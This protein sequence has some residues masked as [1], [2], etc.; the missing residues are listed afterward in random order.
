MDTVP[1]K[2]G[3]PIRLTDERWAHVTE[4][5]AELAGMRREVLSTVEDPERILLGH[6]G[7]HLAIR[8]V[9]SGK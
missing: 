6:A 5:H 1:S 7:E 8:E 4:E 9:D 2:R 3:V